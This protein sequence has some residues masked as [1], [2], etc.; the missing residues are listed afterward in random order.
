MVILGH[1]EEKPDGL[2]AR[3]GEHGRAPERLHVQRA[4]G[5]LRQVVQQGLAQ[6]G[7]HLVRHTAEQHARRTGDRARARR[8]LARDAGGRDQPAG[9]GLRP[10]ARHCL[11]R[12][13]ARSHHPRTHR[14]YQVQIETKSRISK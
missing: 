2:G 14:K 12:H 6:V 7:G 11:P 4:D 8:H 5:L 10:S 1:K 9:G 13:A 3:G